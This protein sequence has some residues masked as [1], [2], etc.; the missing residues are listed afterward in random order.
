MLGSIRSICS[1]LGLC[2]VFDGKIEAIILLFIG[3]RKIPI[4]GTTVQVGSLA[5]SNFPLERW[6]LWLGH[7]VFNDHHGR[8]FFSRDQRRIITASLLCSEGSLSKRQSQRR[9]KNQKRHVPFDLRK[10]IPTLDIFKHK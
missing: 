3:D 10:P 2:L 4:G 7:T 8:F 9:K 5:L 6:T 1:V